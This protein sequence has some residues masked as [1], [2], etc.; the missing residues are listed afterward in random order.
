MP[1]TPHWLPW[2]TPVLLAA[3]SLI[4]ALLPTS[5][6]KLLT[7]TTRAALAFALL[8][9]GSQ[10]LMPPAVTLP[11]GAQTGAVVLVLVTLLGWII[12]DFSQ[13]YLH[14]EPGQS[15]YVVAYLSTLAG[16]CT[17]AASNNLAVL[18][19][20]WAASSIG[21]HHLLTFYRERLA[22]VI[23]AHKKFL[24]SRLA[25]VC[26]VAAAALLYHEW[27]TLDLALLG[28]RAAAA[29]TL[30]MAAGAAA[31]LIAIAVLLKCAQ[32]PLHGWLIQV[33]EAPTPVSAL[34]HAGVVNLGGY[35]LIRLAPLIGASPT[36]QSLL[37]VVGGLTAALAGLVMLTRV[38]IKVRLAW[39][40]CSQ[41]GLMIMEC[42]LGLYDLALLHLLAHAL[43]KAHA[44]L[45]AGETVRDSVTRKL[46]GNA[47]AQTAA[48][49]A[50]A[51]WLSALCAL[52]VTGGIVFGSALAWAVAL[53]SNPPHWI[54]LTILSYGL[55]TALWGHHRIDR[56]ALNSLL[57]VWV[58][59]QL[60]LL[61]HS[62]LTAL[63][64]LTAQPASPV[65]AALSTATLLGL[66]AMQAWVLHN[67]TAAGR[68]HDWAYAGFYL[69]ERFTSLTFRLWPARPSSESRGVA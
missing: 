57:T 63:P 10:W 68:L 2:V 25:E 69:D 48:P 52:L 54:A 39:S 65:L 26:L 15:R 44:F 5:H 7:L 59:S 66:Y 27:G 35:V 6:W 61:W 31:T 60:Y 67:R 53:H 20:G 23:V 37:V 11:A 28:E 38:T 46:V 42:G 4:T 62:V 3:G 56:A 13:R 34:L 33:M 9:L 51:V 64:G 50:I 24:A 18:I 1:H 58:C 22:A 16:V 19:A 32:L 12:G 30:S 43:Y 29:G 45:T 14:G 55:A 36:A 8:T 17:V 49:T 40:T 21:L 41:M 47:A